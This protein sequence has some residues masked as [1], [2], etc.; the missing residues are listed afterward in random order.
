M[1][2]IFFLLQL[3]RKLYKVVNCSEGGDVMKKSELDKKI[4]EFDKKLVGDYLVPITVSFLTTAGLLLL[5][6]K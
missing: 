5:F 6:Y 2:P 4:D 3:Y 1:L